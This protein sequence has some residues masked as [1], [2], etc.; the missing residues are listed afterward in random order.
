MDAGTGSTAGGF[1][2]TS[3]ER[4]ADTRYNE[5][6]KLNSGE[7]RSFHIPEQLV[8]T[9]ATSV[10][11][12]ITVINQ[13]SSG[14]ITTQSGG[15][16]L[17]FSGAG[18][19]ALSAILPIQENGLVTLR[20]ASGGPADVAV[21]VQGYQKVS[22]GN[23]SLAASPVQ[24]GTVQIAS[25]AT[26]KVKVA[27][28]GAIPSVATTPSLGAIVLRLTSDSATSKG[29]LKAWPADAG[30]P[31]TSVLNLDP[32]QPR[33]DALLIVEVDATDQIAVKNYSPGV[34]SVS[35]SVQGWILN[36]GCIEADE[37]SGQC[38]TAV[39]QEGDD[40]YLGVMRSLT[41]QGLTSQSVEFRK[42]HSVEFAEP[43]RAAVLE[44]GDYSS[45][46]LS[47]SPGP[48]PS[49]GMGSA[50]GTRWSLTKYTY[51]VVC[52]RGCMVKGKYR[53]DITA[54]VFWW[55]EI[56]T[57]TDVTR[58]Y[59]P[60]FNLMKYTAEVWEDKSFWADEREVTIGY[61]SSFFRGIAKNYLW[62]DA[63]SY[64]KRPNW[65]NGRRYY[66]AYDVWQK[67]SVS[68]SPSYY[69]NWDSKRFKSSSSN[70]TA[71][72]GYFE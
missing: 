25:G 31:G 58:V 51:F 36:E 17:N 30:E 43:Q 69:A 50:G 22:S 6:G 2:V 5:G 15:T 61:D 27:G 37:I 39:I 9:D 29:Y 55:P 13:A 54:S 52:Q 34:V 10:F 26:A 20:L 11:V 66:F 70:T 44:S 12:N 63:N 19:Q 42:A 1:Q 8:P 24:F 23:F 41:Q 49:P 14:W 59:G 48:S 35:F 7:Y 71:N 38:G 3:Q 53:Y 4:I 62:L 28:A 65:P 56:D 64:R 46:S 67:V 47:P 18:P 21:D 60:R 40:P 57:S 32:E 33:Q 16:S 68:R 72:G 45:I